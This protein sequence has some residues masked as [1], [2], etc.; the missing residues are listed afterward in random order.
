MSRLRYWVKMKVLEG[1][2]TWIAKCEHIG[3]AKL[4]GYILATFNRTT[5]EWSNTKAARTAIH[6]LYG[7]EESTA[8]T[9]LTKLVKVGLLVKSGRGHYKVNSD[10]ISYGEK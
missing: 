5:G 7:I 2:T 3:Q 4:F 6:Q 9:Y 10:Y 8:Y 1:T